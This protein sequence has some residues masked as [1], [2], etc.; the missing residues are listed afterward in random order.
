MSAG[1]TE[2]KDKR[3]LYWLGDRLIDHRH[4]IMIVVLGVTAVF[5]YWAFQMKLETS[6][7]D[8]LP[9]TH[10]FIQI[11]NKYAGTFGGANNVQLMVEAKDGNIFNVPTLARIYKITEAVD[12]VYGVNH[13]QIDSIGHRTTR[14]LRAQSGGFLR[15]EPVMIGLPKTPDDAANIRRIVHNTESVSGRLV[16]LDDKAALVRANFIEG[17]LDHRRTFEEINERVIA[18]FERGWIGALIKGKDPLKPD[19]VTPALIEVVY[20]GT[21][22][23]EADL[24]PGDVVESVNG[25]P[26][27]DRTAMARGGSTDDAGKEDVRGYK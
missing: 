2:E 27:P 26:T 17:R 1:T 4:P 5:A 20:R 9:Q 19:Q 14:Y 15:A 10:P 8:L 18:P 3:A 21:P 11:H 7:G 13:N 16:S 24:K 22:A 23:G 25:V 12:Q 6:F